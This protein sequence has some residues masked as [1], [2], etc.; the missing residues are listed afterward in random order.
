MKFRAKTIPESKPAETPI[1][2]NWDS[3]NAYLSRWK[4]DTYLDVEIT[5]RRTNADPIRKYYFVAVLPGICK[6]AGYEPDES[7]YVHAD[8]KCRYFKNQ[9]ELLEKLKL[10]VPYRDERMIWRNVP[11]VFA[12][13]SVIPVRNK[14]EFVD[15]V[16]RKAAQYGVYVESASG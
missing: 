1:D 5:R 8:L 11:D 7:D 15:W 4:A 3:V 6:G 10:K 12:D 16:I 9:L 2:I 13:D 14:A